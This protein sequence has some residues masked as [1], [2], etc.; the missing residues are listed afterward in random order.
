MCVL[1]NG[2]VNRISCD[3]EGLG[4]DPSEA[5]KNICGV[6][7]VDNSTDSHKASQISGC[8]K[9]LAELRE[10]HHPGRPAMGVS[11]ALIQHP[12]EHI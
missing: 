9:G 12:D 7:I 4:N 8:E 2:L 11:P 10:A 5:V 3:R 6:S 1:N